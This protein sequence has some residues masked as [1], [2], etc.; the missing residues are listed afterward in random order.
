MP[1]LRNEFILNAKKDEQST[2]SRPLYN[3]NN[4]L[5]IQGDRLSVDSKR[6]NAFPRN[7]NANANQNHPNEQT[8]FTTVNTDLDALSGTTLPSISEP[9]SHSQR[10]RGYAVMDDPYAVQNRRQN[11][12]LR[13]YRWSSSSVRK[14]Y[15]EPN[16]NSRAE[17][18]ELS[19]FSTFASN[20]LRSG[21]VEGEQQQLNPFE[22]KSQSHAS[23]LFLNS[24]SSEETSDKDH[25]NRRLRQ[26]EQ[27]RR[28]Q[29]GRLPYY[30]YT[31]LPYFSIV[32]SMG[33]IVVF[34]VELVRM[35]VLT[36][37][38]FQT[39]PYF[40]PMLGPSTYL[41]INMG[42][43]YV[44][45]MHPIA[46]VTLD[47]SLQFPCPNS[48]AV[49]TNVC[50]LSELCGM[51]GIPIING[52][53]FPNQHVRIVTPIFLHA[54]FLHILFNMM[55]QLAMGMGVERHIGSIKY[56]LIYMGSGV[57][58]FLLGASFAPNGIASTGASGSLFGIIAANLLLFIYCGR[59]N[60]NIYF[61]KK[62]T[63]FILLMVSEVVVSF[64]LGLLP[65][66]DN[67]S[68]IGGFCM[69]LIL[70][71]ALLQDPSFV[72]LD[73]IYTYN[74]TA[75]TWEMIVSHWNPIYN[76]ND[77]IRWKVAVW[78]IARL[79][80]AALV[81]VYFILLSRNLYLA[82]MEQDKMVCSWCK[83]I[84]CIPVNNW[85]E[86]GEVTV[87]TENT[88]SRRSDDFATTDHYFHFLNHD[89][90]AFLSISTLTPM[91]Q[92]PDIIVDHYTSILST[93]IL[94]SMMA[95]LSFSS[96]RRL[97]NRESFLS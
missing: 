70:S 41:L 16:F 36:G 90:L 44:P 31:K 37:S 75:S 77:K 97:K 32:V 10:G 84:N 2:E 78:A 86:M 62:Y 45:C 63:L 30:H 80:C 18:H 67:F 1:A 56:G 34:I 9:E 13:S 7:Y 94:A 57:A 38:P 5:P 43:R 3:T 17:Q 33:Q 29:A 87:T 66:L 42:A 14:F 93:V 46:N 96:I 26:H 51:G 40:N 21:V 22:S 59:K 27:N 20:P 19:D 24:D 88:P 25:V 49:S 28:K 64:V 50:N 71:V 85:C 15:R 95:L 82:H 72:Y 74:P 76:I 55:L 39:R 6:N 73:G 48:T 35:G 69:G 53:Y 8:P 92:L 12:L 81:I 58:G 61:T 65:G 91:L 79:A 89:R 83:Y 23:G 47:M 68:H 52:V 54:G 4:H 11:E 60:T